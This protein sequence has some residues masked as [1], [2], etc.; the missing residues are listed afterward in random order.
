MEPEKI[1]LEAKELLKFSH[2]GKSLFHKIEELKGILSENIDNY[3]PLIETH[4]QPPKK[5]NYNSEGIK[6]EL[7][8]VGE[9]LWIPAIPEKVKYNAY[10]II[11]Q[12][13]IDYIIDHHVSTGVIEMKPGLRFVDIPGKIFDLI[14]EKSSHIYIW[15]IIHTREDNLSDFLYPNSQVI[16]DQFQDV[17]EKSDKKEVIKLLL[18]YLLNNPHYF[19]HIKAEFFYHWK[20]LVDNQ[21]IAAE[22]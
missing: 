18:Y 16:K 13:L 11:P 9:N 17:D 21:L 22:M 12:P 1:L 15:G 8:R 2:I 10:K 4:T 5:V 19:S 6:F 14:F 3:S 20:P 7:R